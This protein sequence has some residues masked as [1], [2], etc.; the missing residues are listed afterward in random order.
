MPHDHKGENALKSDNATC[1]GNETDCSNYDN[2]VI[3]ADHKNTQS[4]QC[5][6]TNFI[7]IKCNIF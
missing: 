3:S 1:T 4:T 7:I 6:H 2:K 5:Y